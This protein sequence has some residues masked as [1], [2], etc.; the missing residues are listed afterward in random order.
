MIDTIISILKAVGFGIVWLSVLFLTLA[1]LGAFRVQYKKLAEA[2][3]K[4]KLAALDN[5]FEA[6]DKAEAE[7]REN[8]SPSLEELAH[9]KRTYD[10]EGEWDDITPVYEQPKEI[11]TSGPGPAPNSRGGYS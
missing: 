4:A 8:P 10:P 11:F 7:E 2:E 3:G 9:L 6:L 5:D 1:I